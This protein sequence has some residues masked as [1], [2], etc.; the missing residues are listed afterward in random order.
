VNRRRA[1]FWMLPLAAAAIPVIG[2]FASPAQG[3]RPRGGGAHRGH[4]PNLGLTTRE[5]RPVRLYDDLLRGRTVL[6]AFLDPGCAE[7]ACVATAEN[8]AR[9]AR[10]LGERCGRDVFL[11]A[12]TPPPGG[13]GPDAAAGAPA[14]GLKPAGLG[15]GWTVLSGSGRSLARCRASFGLA[16]A[17]GGRHRGSPPHANAVVIGNEP[18]ERWLAAAALTDPEVLLEKLDRV[19]GI[20]S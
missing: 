20:R 3:R 19:A 5:G 4:F 6:A 12:F 2:R 7:A 15:P 10:A 16:A 9:L 13:G 11:Y 8:L 18:H 14:R 17:A 1:L